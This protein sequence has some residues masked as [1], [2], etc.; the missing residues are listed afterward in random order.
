[1]P[2]REGPEV[3]HCRLRD[4]ITLPLQPRRLIIVN[5]A[6]GCKRWLASLVKPTRACLCH[7]RRLRAATSYRSLYRLPMTSCIFAVSTYCWNLVTLPSATSQIW[8]T[9]A[10]MLFPVALYV[11]VYRTST[12]T[13]VP[14]P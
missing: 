3:I 5:A 13:L 2:L 12:M 9:C 1:M 11:P 6:D 4:G 8:Q 10:S 7:F 14:A